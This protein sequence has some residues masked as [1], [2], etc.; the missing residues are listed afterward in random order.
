MRAMCSQGRVHDATTHANWGAQLLQYHMQDGAPAAAGLVVARMVS[1]KGATKIKRKKR[2][3]SN[4]QI[5]AAALMKQLV[6]AIYGETPVNHAEG[7]WTADASDYLRKNHK[8]L[9]KYLGMRKHVKK[10]S[11]ARAHTP[12]PAHDAR[13]C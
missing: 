6:E 8:V 1:L 7:L 2:P 11:A 9:D 5:T 4:G 10:A 13:P 3:R 12:P